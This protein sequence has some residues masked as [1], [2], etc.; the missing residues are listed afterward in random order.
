MLVNTAVEKRIEE[1]FGPNKDRYPGLQN[2]ADDVRT[3]LLTG[4]LVVVY[5]RR[6][7]FVFGAA[8]DCSIEEMVSV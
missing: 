8:P 5:Y 2:I 3:Q 4:K 1:I 6:D 7:G